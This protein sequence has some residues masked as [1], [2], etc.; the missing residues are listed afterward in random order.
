MKILIELSFS[1]ER[2]NSSL[3]KNTYSLINSDVIKYRYYPLA[4]SSLEKIIH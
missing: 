2:E 4:K 3:M 1:Q